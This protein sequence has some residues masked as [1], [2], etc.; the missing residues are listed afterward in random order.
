M[1]H[2][3]NPPDIIG[4][5]NEMLG[6]DVHANQKNDMAKN[7]AESMATFNLN[8]GGT[9]FGA[10]SWALRSYCGLKNKMY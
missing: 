5:Q 2:P 8:S 10:H 9:G 4:A 3:S 7:G 6:K 1:L